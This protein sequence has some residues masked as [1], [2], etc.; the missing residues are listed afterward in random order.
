MLRY[1]VLTEYGVQYLENSVCSLGTNNNSFR[2]PYL[3][4]SLMVAFSSSS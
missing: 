4:C 3:D 2:I 1:Y